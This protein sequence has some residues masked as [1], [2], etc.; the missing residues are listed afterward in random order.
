MKNI[1]WTNLLILSIVAAAFTSYFD[2]TIDIGYLLL[3]FSTITLI[4]YLK[5]YV[6][7]DKS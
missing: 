7:K 6:K 5:N 3:L 1:S 4:I 2:I